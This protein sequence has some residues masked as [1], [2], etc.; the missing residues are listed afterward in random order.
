M[1]NDCHSCKWLNPSVSISALMTLIDFTLSNTRQFYTSMGNPSATEGLNSTFRP[2][3]ITKLYRFHSQLSGS[4]PPSFI[5]VV[6]IF[7]DSL[8]HALFQLHW[9]DIKFGFQLKTQVKLAVR[10]SL[11]EVTV[12]NKVPRLGDTIWQCNS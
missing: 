8:S 10:E 9:K 11:T 12:V 4:L 2:L 7:Y 5:P 1:K 6:C 3:N